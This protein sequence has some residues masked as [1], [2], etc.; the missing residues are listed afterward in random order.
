[1]VSL[2]S[3]ILTALLSLSPRPVAPY[4]GAPVETKEAHR[5]RL[6]QYANDLATVVTENP[7]AFQGPHGAARSAALLMAIARHES[8]FSRDVDLGINRLARTKAGQE[9]RGRSWCSLQINL[10]K[11]RVPLGDETM[12]SWRG[13]DLLQDRKKCLRVGLEIARRSVAS[14]TTSF[15]SDPSRW[16]NMY[17][18]G[19][20]RPDTNKCDGNSLCLDFAAKKLRDASKKSKDRVRTYE[21]LWSRFGATA[22]T[23]VP[24]NADAT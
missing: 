21:L 2:S 16:L 12:R 4:I 8:A 14:C 11:G 10:G 20:C 5:E 6:E 22:P 3:W 1:M 17:A 9:D 13:Q 24:E 19:E 18:S 15:P 7:S 23:S